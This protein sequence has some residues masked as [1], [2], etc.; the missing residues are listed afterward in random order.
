M[1]NNITV[2]KQADKTSPVLRVAGK[3]GQSYQGQLTLEDY[4]ARG[5]LVRSIVFELQSVFIDSV[6][7]IDAGEVI[8][9]SC[10]RVKLLSSTKGKIRE[11]KR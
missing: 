6:T 4:S 7:A 10:R 1:L 11:E 2:F 3:N 8:A 9:L 5:S